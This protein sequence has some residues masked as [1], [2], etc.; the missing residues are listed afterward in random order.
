MEF[1]STT[2]AHMFAIVRRAGKDM[3]V[4]KVRAMFNLFSDIVMSLTDHVILL[5]LLVEIPAYCF[6]C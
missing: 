3:I 5:I 1:V 2:M 4:K 6:R